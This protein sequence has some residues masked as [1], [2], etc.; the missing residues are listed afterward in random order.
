M[1][2]GFRK[3]LRRGDNAE[4]DIDRAVANYID[5]LYAI[6]LAYLTGQMSLEQAKKNTSDEAAGA[7]V[8][9]FYSGFDSANG[10]EP[11]GADR[12]WIVR[13]YAEEV[14]YIDDLFENLKLKRELSLEEL[15]Y[16]SLALFHAGGYA[17]TA[18]GIYN[19]GKLRGRLD[20]LLTMDGPDGLESCV[21]CQS[22]K[23][24]THPARWWIE[25]DL[26]PGP[27]TGHN[28][29]CK[30]FNCQHRLYNIS[31]VQYTL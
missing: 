20:E 9:A 30:G 31:G 19:Q 2:Q 15:A 8:V 10:D 17:K 25:N 18:L 4:Y 1:L 23:L 21:T 5:A 22:L 27:E 3:L 6:F 16:I 28:Y 24:Q 14:A 29:E 11:T 26:V 7:F 13:R 12:A